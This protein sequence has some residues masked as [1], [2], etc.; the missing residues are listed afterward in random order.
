MLLTLKFRCKMQFENIFL[1]LSLAIVFLVHP[2][3]N[4]Q[5]FSHL[6]LFSFKKIA[7]ECFF[8]DNFFGD[9]FY[10]K[11]D[12][13]NSVQKCFLKCMAS[14][15]VTIY[16][17]IQPGCYFSRNAK[18][19]AGLASNFFRMQLMIIPFLKN[20]TKIQHAISMKQENTLINLVSR[21]LRAK[22]FPESSQNA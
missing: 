9:K 14:Q 6:Y 7:D 1:L 8:L 16:L 5:Y 19:L 11:E 13:V 2:I 20:I 21:K 22:A 10:K 4:G 18:L 3:I 15:V 17:F 12:G